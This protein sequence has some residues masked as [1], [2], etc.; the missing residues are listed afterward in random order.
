MTEYGKEFVPF[1]DRLADIARARWLRKFW[2]YRLLVA[3]AVHIDALVDWCVLAL[4]AR[5]PQ[6]AP[7]DA[8]PVLGHERGIRRG[9][10]ES[11]ESYAARLVLWLVDRRIKGSPYAL[12]SQ[13]A[14]YFT[15]YSVR[16]RV[17]NAAGSW[18][19]RYSDGTLDWHYETPSNWDWD[20]DSSP[21]SRYWVILYFPTALA[22]TEG[23]WAQPVGPGGGVWGDGGVWGLNNAYEVNNTVK[24]IVAEWNPPHSRCED[25]II[26][27]D[28]TSFAPT[29]S[30]T[31]YA[32]GTWY[33]AGRDDAGDYVMTRP[34]NRRFFGSVE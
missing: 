15:G 23:L 30:G 34:Y 9:F 3:F 28:A 18:Y 16:I 26:T 22:S 7:P 27:W 1:R 10:S 20:G 17:V 8:L 33:R 5:Y 25:I 13:L 21:F 4:Q 31:G 2:L 11:L 32:D 12:M 29:G 14:G 24:L 19:T 6:M